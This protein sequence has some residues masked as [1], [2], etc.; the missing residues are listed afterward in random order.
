MP[1]FVYETIDK[2]LEQKAQV[3]DNNNLPSLSVTHR[4]MR[5]PWPL[6]RIPWPL[7][8]INSYSFKVKIMSSANPV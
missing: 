5:L 7:A 2:Y 6:V 1:H 4:I 3:R 8:R